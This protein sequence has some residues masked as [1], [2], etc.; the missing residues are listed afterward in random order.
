MVRRSKKVA[1]EARRIPRLNP[2][3]F[4]LNPAVV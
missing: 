3:P 4:T 2:P 1:R